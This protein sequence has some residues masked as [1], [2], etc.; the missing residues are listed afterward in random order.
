MRRNRGYPA[1]GP[2]GGQDSHRQSETEYLAQADEVV[3]LLDE[4]A[5]IGEMAEYL[6]HA[7]PG[8]RDEDRDWRTTCTWAYNQ[9]WEQF[10]TTR[11]TQA[12]ILSFGRSTMRRYGIPV[13]F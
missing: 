10:L 6:A 11:P 2:I 5:A 13:G 3:R 4:A 9:A 7:G 12:Q 8:D 1:L